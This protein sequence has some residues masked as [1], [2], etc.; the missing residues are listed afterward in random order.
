MNRREII[1]PARGEKLSVSPETAGFL[2][3]R[4]EHIVTDDLLRID[5]TALVDGLL[6]QIGEHIVLGIIHAP[7][8]VHIELFIESQLITFMIQMRGQLRHTRQRSSH[9]IAVLK[10]AVFPKYRQAPGGAQLTIQKGIKQCATVIFDAHLMPSCRRHRRTRLELKRRRIRMRTQHP[11]TARLLRLPTASPSDD[12]A[13]TH[14]EMPA[15]GSLIL[16]RL[17]FVQLGKPRR[18]QAPR[19]GSRRQI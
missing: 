15:D 10:G 12:R 6:C 17:G 9:H 1:Q 19:H 7:N 13:V 8:G 11:V 18:L 3:I 14:H 5:R 2:R 4:K 16:P